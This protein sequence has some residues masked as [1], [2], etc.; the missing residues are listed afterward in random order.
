MSNTEKALSPTYSGN[1]IEELIR[2]VD[3]SEPMVNGSR[4]TQKQWNDAH[5]QHIQGN[6]CEEPR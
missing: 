2:V 5:I 1:L 4:F 6:L 3:E